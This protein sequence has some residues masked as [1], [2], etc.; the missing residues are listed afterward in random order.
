M[1]TS[2]LKRH[3]LIRS[4]LAALVNTGQILSPSQ[5]KLFDPEE[6]K[7]LE[8]IEPEVVTLPKK[9]RK[10]KL[11]LKEQFKTIPSRQVSV[12]TLSDEEKIYSICGSQIIPIGTEIIRTKVIYKRS[13][14]ERIK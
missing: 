3:G 6:E 1:I 14:L 7:P 9:A 2:R 8:L 4:F 13:K 12:E 5:M 10:K 11:T